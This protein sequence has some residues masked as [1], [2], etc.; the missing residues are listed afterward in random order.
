MTNHYHL[1]VETPDGNLSKGMRHLNGVYT[2]TYN[3]VHNKV[4]H[5]FQGRF[6]AIIV[7]K[8]EYLLQLCKYIVLNPVKAN[9]VEN[10]EDWHWSSY[11]AT[12]GFSKAPNFLNIK[13]ILSQFHV[14]KQKSINEYINYVNNGK[15]DTQLWK[16]LKGQIVLGKEKYIEKIKEFLNE[17]KN[18][19]ELAS[20]SRHIDRPE[21]KILFEEN[22]LV[23]KKSRNIKI[24]LA[25]LKH[26][27]T[28]KEIAK[29]LGL[30]Y[31]TISK[32]IIENKKN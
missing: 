29:Y 4:G 1:L 23:D 20:E 10:A 15:D 19:Q 7:D 21:L 17:K 25:Y 24:S 32:V 16:N 5:V 12:V 2:Q 22:T 26:G 9:L 8:E 27:Y 30:H 31:T 3:R 13:W 11:R 28:L 18:E 6:K 14:D